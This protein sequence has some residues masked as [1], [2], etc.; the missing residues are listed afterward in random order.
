MKKFFKV[1]LAF[2]LTGIWATLTCGGTMFIGNSIYD[3]SSVIVYGSI[4]LFI[5][6]IVGVIILHFGLKYA[7]KEEKI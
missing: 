5:S 7:N 6:I 3:N 4:S 1:V 2:F